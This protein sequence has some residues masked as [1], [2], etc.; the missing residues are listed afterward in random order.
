MAHYNAEAEPFE[1]ASE[2]NRSGQRRPSPGELD[3]F[4]RQM[5]RTDLE[6]KL[7]KPKRSSSIWSRKSRRASTGPPQPGSASQLTSPSTSSLAHA[8]PRSVNGHDRGESADTVPP[9]PIMLSRSIVPDRLPELPA[10]YKENTNHFVRYPLHN[11]VGPRWY[12]NYHLTAPAN[13]RPSGP[14]S[15]FSASFPPIASSGEAGPAPSR[16]ASNSPLPTPNSPRVITLICWTLPDP[17]GA[18]WHHESPYDVGLSSS[19]ASFE[20]NGH[21]SPTAHAAPNG[22]AGT[23]RSLS[24]SVQTAQNRRKTVTPSPLSQSTSAIH[25]QVPEKAQI[26]RKL[27]KRRTVGI[28]GRHTSAPTSPADETSPR[29]ESPASLGPS[30][31]APTS[32]SDRRGS[33]LGRLVKRFSVIRKPQPV[34]A[35]MRVL[36]TP[37]PEKRQPSP[38]KRQP[39]PEKLHAPEPV[40]RVPPPLLHQE[41][42]FVVI[43][44]QPEPVRVEVDR[45]S[46]ISIEAEIP[47]T[48][49]RLTVANP[50]PGSVESTPVQREIPLPREERAVEHERVPTDET[51]HSTP[52]QSPIVMPGIQLPQ[53]PARSPEPVASSS[54]LPVPSQRYSSNTVELQ[55]TSPAASTPPL[56]PPPPPPPEKPFPIL[57]HEERPFSGPPAS[58][59]TERSSSPSK[60]QSSR[61]RVQSPPAG[62]SASVGRPPSQSPT[63]APVGRPQS[64]SPTKGKPMLEKPQPPPPP[65]SPSSPSPK[66]PAVPFPPH[67]EQPPV[68]PSDLA[69]TL[70]EMTADISP[71]STSSMLVNPPT[72]YTKD[73]PIPDEPEPAPPPVPS[74]RSSRDPSPVSVTGRG[75]RDVPSRTQRFRDGWEVIE[76]SSSKNKGKNRSQDWENDS[77][78]E[79]RRQAKAEKEPEPDQRK[80][81]SERRKRRSADGTRASIPEPF[82]SPPPPQQERSKR[83]DERERKA[84]RKPVDVDKPQPAP[85]GPAPPVPARNPSRTS[86]SARP[87]SEVPTAADMNQMKAREAWDMDRLWKARSMSGMEAN[88]VA[89]APGPAPPV[90]PMPAPERKEYRESACCIRL[91]PYSVHGLDAVPA[92]G[93]FNPAIP[94]HAPRP[95][96]RRL[97][98][99][100]IR[101]TWAPPVLTTHRP[102]PPSIHLYPRNPSLILSPNPRE[103]PLTNPPRF[104][105]PT[106]GASTLLLLPLHIDLNKKLQYT[107]HHIICNDGHLHIRTVQ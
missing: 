86:K 41:E 24:P 76:S 58:L 57:Y 103:N 75:N 106:I 22:R 63:K 83:D 65:S 18:P 8:Q 28:F 88:G 35:P 51:T 67:F 48:M 31:L 37:S 40:K 36:R 34:V 44:P 53:S 21:S 80:P 1:E 73:K 96:P 27:S 32:K 47:Y 26:S 9:M 42:S 91:K 70:P 25:L 105:S 11:P 12:K 19:P 101:S 10:W 99:Q 5:E 79:Q 14:P 13:P 104:R 55:P 107:L 81:R 87:T 33:V 56:S 45:T 90:P 60:A 7:S 84:E 71:L 38:E 54:S 64:Q 102:P 100:G 2:G 82:V 85:P 77:R 68:S 72:P 97:P 94:L 62:T 49:G 74:K 20:E 15:V 61:G 30:F 52:T 93:L 66:L 50:D 16:S 98:P 43:H 46:S 59:S 92:A 4:Y 89:A 6:R 23:I 95:S 17:W 29:G 69:Y 3:A 78:K 39:S